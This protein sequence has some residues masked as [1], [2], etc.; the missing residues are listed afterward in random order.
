MKKKPALKWLQSVG[1]KFE[2]DTNASYDTIVMYNRKMG[3]YLMIGIKN[4]KVN[5]I[6]FGN[7]D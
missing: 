6:T 4:D 2:F 1:W 7:L 3:K 5:D